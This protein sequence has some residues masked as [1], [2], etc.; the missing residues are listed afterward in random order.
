MSYAVKDKRFSFSGRGGLVTFVDGARRAEL[1]WEG[2]FAGP[3]SLIINGENCRWTAP[4]SRK[5]TRAEVRLLVREFASAVGAQIDLAFSDGHEGV[6][7][8]T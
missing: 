8:G 6:Q 7:P 2:L 3:S 5:M 4:E 1:D